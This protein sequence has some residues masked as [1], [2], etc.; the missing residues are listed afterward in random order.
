MEMLVL[1]RRKVV[2]WAIAI[3]TIG[4]SGCGGVT[5]LGSTNEGRGAS[6]GSDADG[7]AGGGANLTTGGRASL[8]SGGSAGAPCRGA[9]CG[10]GGQSAG[11]GGQPAGGFGSGGRSAGGA[12]PGGAGMGG[13]IFDAGSDPG[14]NR[15]APGESCHRLSIIQCAAEAFCCPSAPALE[16]CRQNMLA[17]CNQYG[18]F[19]HIASNPVI[20]YDIDRAEA[21]L[22]EFERRASS[23][24][25][26]I[27]RWAISD[28][29]FRGVARGTLPPGADCQP[30]ASM[31]YNLLV[32]V[33]YLGSCAEPEKMACFGEAP[34]W[35]CAPRSDL[36]GP[37]MTELNCIDG[38]HCEWIGPG[39]RCVER[40][41]NGAACGQM[42][43]CQSLHCDVR[44]VCADPT[45]TDVYCLLY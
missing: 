32:S 34:N 37:C 31:P 40:K 6:S 5:R 18:A 12:L 2:V 33:G 16:M 19:E 42:F 7:G 4:G 44:G 29:G 20:G 36:G 27:V 39:G 43:E 3:G 8:G 13:R 17:A 23:C 30:M 28:A 41:P 14:R 11:A 21:A 38:L 22:G 35:T 15:V 25:T 24:D 9:E 1:G 26:G 45:V 10:P